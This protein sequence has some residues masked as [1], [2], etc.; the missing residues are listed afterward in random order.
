[1]IV[2]CNERLLLEIEEQPSSHRFLGKRGQERL[3]PKIQ[4][5]DECFRKMLQH[6]RFSKHIKVLPR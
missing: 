3:R 1:M 5:N 6:K 4:R 2:C